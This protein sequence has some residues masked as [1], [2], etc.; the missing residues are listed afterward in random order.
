MLASE[1]FQLQ[2]NALVWTIWLS[3]NTD[4]ELEV[5]DLALPL[6]FNTQYVWDKTETYTKRLIAH[7][8]IAGN[9]S[10]IFL[11]R[12]NTERPY[13]VMTPLPDTA[14]AHFVAPRTPPSYA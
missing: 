12:T 13:L 2:N 6:P 1:K 10:F 8:L 5:G 14:L 3:N 9:G 7:R 11:L 4:H